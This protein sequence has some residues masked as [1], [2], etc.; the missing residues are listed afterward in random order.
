MRPPREWPSSSY[1]LVLGLCLLFAATR[2]PPV[3][4]YIVSG[5]PDQ[6]PVE[7]TDVIVMGGAV[8]TPVAEFDMVARVLSTERYRFDDVAFLIPL[9]VVVG[10]GEMSN[11]ATVSELTVTQVSRRYYLGGPS[12][13]PW[14]SLFEQ[15][16]NMHLIPSSGAV[17]HRVLSVRAGG[18]VHIWGK[19]VNVSLPNGGRMNTS[20]VRTD[21]G[22]GACEILYVDSLMILPHR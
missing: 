19:L 22:D 18:T 7:D 9:D 20:T 8:L 14:S 13:L 2:G 21:T 6:V 15:S 17:R 4:T 16:A 12:G 5:E 1:L 10:W 11:A 3:D